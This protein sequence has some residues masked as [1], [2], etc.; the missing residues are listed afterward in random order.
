MQVFLC[1][2]ETVPYAKCCFVRIPAISIS[3]SSIFTQS[4]FI[5]FCN[6]LNTFL[7][8]KIENERLKLQQEHVHRSIASIP[9]SLFTPSLALP[10]L[11]AV[12]FPGFPQTFFNATQ[13]GSLSGSVSIGVGVGGDAKTGVGGGG[14]VGVV[15]SSSA[16]AGPGAG[17]VTYGILAAT[18][19]FGFTGTMGYEDESEV[20]SIVAGSGSGSGSGTGSGQ[21]RKVC[22]ILFIHIH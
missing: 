7:E 4:Y 2:G 19:A 21:K 6:S 8:L 20:T 17:T 10:A 9:S 12:G 16:A 13:D 22:L 15:G 3:P 18:N 1:D 5:L 14:G 11:S